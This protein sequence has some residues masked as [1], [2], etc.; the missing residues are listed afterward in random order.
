MYLSLTVPLI[1]AGYRV[2]LQVQRLKE[3]GAAT[4]RVQW[5]QCPWCT[6]VCV[7]MYWCMC[8]YLPLLFAGKENTVRT[9]VT[10]LATVWSHSPFS[11]AQTVD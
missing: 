2:C 7:S 3:A 4:A 5:R 1:S 11:E 8:I 10:I 9:K 6:G